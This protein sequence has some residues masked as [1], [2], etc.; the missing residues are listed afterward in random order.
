LIDVDPANPIDRLLYGSHS[1][2]RSRFQG[3]RWII[4]VLLRYCGDEITCLRTVQAVF[5]R[6]P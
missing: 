4:S 1:I 6:Y 3:P 5:R 2:L